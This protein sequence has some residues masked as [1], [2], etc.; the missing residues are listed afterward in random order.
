MMSFFL[1]ILIERL[2]RWQPP[3]GAARGTQGECW[4]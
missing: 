3:G 4:N 1:F 2:K